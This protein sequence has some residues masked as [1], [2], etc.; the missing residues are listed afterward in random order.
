MDIGDPL[1]INYG[2]D[3][4]KNDIVVGRAFDNRSGAFVVLEAARQLSKLKT[5]VKV[6]S[7][8]TS[9]EEIG[10]R[11]AQTSSFEANINRF[12]YSC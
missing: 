9:Q 1:V 4:L 2:F 11:G 12:C 8:A 5:N 10:L 3:D 6:H 7:V